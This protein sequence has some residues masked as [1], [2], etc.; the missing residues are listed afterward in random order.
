M[1]RYTQNLYDVGAFFDRNIPTRN[2]FFGM[3][4]SPKAPVA[5]GVPY[6]ERVRSM[7]PSAPR[8]EPAPLQDQVKNHLLQVAALQKQ[9]AELQAAAGQPGM[10]DFTQENMQA[11]AARPNQPLSREQV[12]RELYDQNGGS[13]AEFRPA[14][15]GGVAPGVETQIQNINKQTMQAA[16]GKEQE[17]QTMSDLGKMVQAYFGGRTQEQKQK[18]A[19]MNI[20]AGLAAGKSPR[21]MDNLGGAVSGA[22]TFQRDDTNRREKEA[23]GFGIQNQNLDDD[24]YFQ[25]G[26]LGLGEERNDIAREQNDISRINAMR[27]RASANYQMKALQKRAGDLS[28]NIAKLQA[29]G[30]DPATIGMMELQL[31]EVMTQLSGTGGV[32][33]GEVP[34]A[35]GGAS[36]PRIK[37]GADGKSTIVNPQ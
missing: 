22:L 33:I 1:S 14:L 35:P 23:L 19:F 4:G 20:A 15:G 17:V 32:G 30:G 12:T 11:E 3:V 2:E 37:M 5:E 13:T 24:R 26:Q 29:E 36:R 16:T 21:F 10:D 25:K 34:A 31:G 9:A 27:Q 6:E 18:E 28:K 8:S 7:F